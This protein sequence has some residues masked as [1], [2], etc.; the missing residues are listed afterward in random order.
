ME[1]INQN[2]YG[3]NQQFAD[4]IINE[5]K[6]L[7]K[8][9]AD[10]LNLIHKN[11]SSEEERKILVE[12]LETIKSDKIEDK[13]KKKLGGILKKFVDSIVTEGGKQLV[14]ELAENGAEYWRYIF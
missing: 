5:S 2:I 14:K 7:D 10:F 6:I 9:D 13:E 3:G 1:I 4:L 11:T 12:S 8:T